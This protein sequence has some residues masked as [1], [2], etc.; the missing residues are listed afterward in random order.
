M[1]AYRRYVIAV[2]VLVGFCA[3][4]LTLTEEE[5]EIDKSES[6]CVVCHTSV[7]MLI[8]LSWEIHYYSCHNTN[9]K[10]FWLEYLNSV[11]LLRQG[12]H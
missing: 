11:R 12:L 1:I 4:S 6:Q 8:R 10:D 9:S 7:K 2:C 3:C 5:P